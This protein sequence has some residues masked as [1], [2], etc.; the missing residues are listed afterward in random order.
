[1]RFVKGDFKVFPLNGRIH[2][3]IDQPSSLCRLFHKGKW[4]DFGKIESCTVCET[5]WAKIECK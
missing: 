3:E 5:I 2:V 4:L 1:M